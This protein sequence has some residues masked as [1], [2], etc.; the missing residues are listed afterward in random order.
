[1]GELK[2]K[3]L[4]PDGNTLW[5]ESLFPEDMLQ[6]DVVAELVEQLELPVLDKAGQR[7]E[8]RLRV[9]NKNLDLQKGKSL[10]E[11]QVADKDTLQ[12]VST[13]PVPP[14]PPKP[15]IEPPKGDTVEVML[16]V[17]DLHGAGKPTKFPLDMTVGEAI[18]EIVRNYKL[19]VRD[20][21]TK[22]LIDYRLTS[23]ARGRERE[24]LNEETF[25][26]AG[27]PN[28]D[29]LSLVREAVAG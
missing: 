18:R 5:G 28:R 12:L 15:L 24:L 6:E 16:S 4:S 22:Q 20:P 9:V 7:V 17:L 19:D 21:A 27:I 23:K 11:Q 10:R 13:A 25:R 8:Y 14:T 1:L 2:L 26:S 29:R 3:F